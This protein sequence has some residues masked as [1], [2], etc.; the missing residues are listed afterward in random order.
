VCNGWLVGYCRKNQA[1]SLFQGHGPFPFGVNSRC[2]IEVGRR[3]RCF[4]SLFPSSL[5]FSPKTQSRNIKSLGSHLLFF[6]IFFIFH[7]HTTIRH[8]THTT[9]RHTTHTA[10]GIRHTTTSPLLFAHSLLTLPPSAWTSTHSFPTNT[11]PPP[12]PTLRPSPFALHPSLLLSFQSLFTALIRQTPHHHHHHHHIHTHAQPL[13]SERNSF[14][15]PHFFFFYVIYPC[16]P[17]LAIW[18]L[19]TLDTPSTNHS[20]P[21]AHTTHG[22]LC[23]PGSTTTTTTDGHPGHSRLHQL[24]L[25]SKK[26][27]IV[28]PMA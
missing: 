9:I 10:H 12:P 25:W 23:L 6:F 27:V 28:C 3:L 5:F 20:T 13:H 1:L 2:L 24:Q 16:D 11:P 22:D 18:G 26:L 14:L 19:S 8:T 15:F 7:T 4:F 21:P 17:A